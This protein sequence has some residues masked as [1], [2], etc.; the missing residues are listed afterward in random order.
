LRLNVTP[1]EDLA[2]HDDHALLPGLT[3]SWGTALVAC[4]LLVVSQRGAG[5]DL[6]FLAF[7]VALAAP[8]KPSADRGF[9]H[10]LAFL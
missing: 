5:V 9:Q 10:R 7:E 8:V 2:Q 6:P 4:C 1:S 3:S